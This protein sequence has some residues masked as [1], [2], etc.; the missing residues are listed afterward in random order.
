M[1][2]M[3]R[4]TTLAL[5]AGSLGLSVAGDA[6]AALAP[7][8]LPRGPART[9]FYLQVQHSEKC[10]HVHSGGWENGALITQWACINQPNVLWTFEPVG[11]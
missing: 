10:M 9:S 4:I 3:L 2:H 1:T 11:H 6:D 8:E 7:V 5:T